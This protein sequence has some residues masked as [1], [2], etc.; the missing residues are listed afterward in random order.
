MGRSID[1]ANDETNVSS[2]NEPSSS[3]VLTFTKDRLVG[4]LSRILAMIS[5]GDLTEDEQRQ[6]FESILN[7][8]PFSESDTDTDIAIDP[9]ALEYLVLGWFVRSHLRDDLS[10]DTGGGEDIDSDDNDT[11]PGSRDEPF[12]HDNTHSLH[13]PTLDDVVRPFL[14]HFDFE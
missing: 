9:R 10:N 12:G 8:P 7:H 2:M 14:G 11:I 3:D 6:I 4:L 13:R 1:N 5:N